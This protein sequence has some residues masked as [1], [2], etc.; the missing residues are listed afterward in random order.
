MAKD[1]YITPTTV[2]VEIGGETYSGSYTHDRGIVTA[3]WDGWTEKTQVG[4]SAEATAKQLVRQLVR[5]HRS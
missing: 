2:E 1:K 3:E 4:A 5:E